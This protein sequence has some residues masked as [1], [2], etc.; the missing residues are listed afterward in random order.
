M[1]RLSNGAAGGPIRRGGLALASLF[2][3]RFLRDLSLQTVG[4]Y[5]S[6][7]LLLVRGILLARLLGPANLGIVSF[8]NIFIAYASWADLG[9]G[10]VPSRE[11]PIALGAGHPEKAEQWRWYGAFATTVCGTL[12]ACG[13]AVYVAINWFTL[14]DDLRFGLLT[15]CV[16]IVASAFTGEQQVIMRAYQRYDRLNALVVFTAIASLAT[17][18]AGAWIAGV[19]GVFVSQ[20]V[21]YSLAVV[22]SLGLAGRPRPSKVRARFLGSMVVAGIP[23]AVINLVG[24]NLINIDQILLVALLSKEALGMYMPVLYAGSAAALFP[25]A[26]VVA[27]GSRL[28]RRY[29]EFRT[30]ESINGLTWR[31]VRGLSVSMPVVC[32]LGWLFAPLGILLVLPEYVEAIAPLRVYLVGVFFLGL[33]MGTGSTLYALNKH[34]YDIPVVLG[35]IALNVALDVVFVT[36]MGLG[37]IGIALGSAITYFAYWIAHTMLVHHYFGHHWRRAT[38]LCLST[39]WPGLV[40]AAV[41]ALA[42]VTGSLSSTLDP[43]GVL[44]F[45][46]A[47]GLF[48]LR[49]KEATRWTL[50]RR[51]GTD[52]KASS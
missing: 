13:I 43:L 22:V 44:L 51:D 11:I 23:Y 30:M 10:R 35:S 50:S 31:P 26:V 52:T 49:W 18:V 7:A 5:L 45:V 42:A 21:V 48:A 37:L 17:G 24:Y 25:N 2:P 29:G 9:M 36:W 38:L 46:A 12:A 19:R 33:N 28:I 14:D 20:A 39:G 16:V 6:T 4:M 8:V 15:A 3:E 47:A 27:T 1:K 40:L 32:A 41:T 34:M